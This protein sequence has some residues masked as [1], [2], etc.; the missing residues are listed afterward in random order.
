MVGGSPV[1]PFRNHSPV[2]AVRSF[3]F[4][5]HWTK[6]NLPVEDEVPAK[7]SKARIEELREHRAPPKEATEDEDRKELEV[8]LE[9][10]ASHRIF[11]SPH[12]SIER[13]RRAWNV[14]G[15]GSVLRRLREK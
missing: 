2:L 5:T 8:G 12:Y 7:D 13:S 11:F 3:T 4:L 14:R 15:D 10:F 9:P 6:T 1:N